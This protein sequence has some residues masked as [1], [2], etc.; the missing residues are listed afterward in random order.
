M[1]TI[2]LTCTKLEVHIHPIIILV[3]HLMCSGY[4]Q[5]A[6]STALGRNRILYFRNGLPCILVRGMD[7]KNHAAGTNERTNLSVR[8][9]V[10]TYVRNVMYVFKIITWSVVAIFLLAHFRTF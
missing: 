4:T 2:I 3:E 9:Y 6:L 7:V 8:M 10:C 5:P 1:C